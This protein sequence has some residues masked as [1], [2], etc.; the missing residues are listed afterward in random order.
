MTVSCYNRLK[1]CTKKV[2][3]DLIADELAD[4]DL[5][6]ERAEHA[7]NWNSEGLIDC[8]H[9]TCLI[10]LNIKILGIWNYMESLRN[11]V[12]DLNERVVKAQV[13]FLELF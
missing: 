12:S 5:Q 10:V 9:Q 2:E 4:I 8:L 6:L 7:L 11:V 13:N 1:T 3:F